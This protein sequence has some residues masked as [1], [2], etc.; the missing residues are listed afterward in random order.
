LLLLIIMFS[1]FFLLSPLVHHWWMYLFQYSKQFSL[2]LTLILNTKKISVFSGRPWQ[3]HFRKHSYSFIWNAVTF[4]HFNVHRLCMEHATEQHTYYESPEP[5][6]PNWDHRAPLPGTKQGNNMSPINAFRLL[7]QRIMKRCVGNKLFQNKYLPQCT[8]IVL[9]VRGWLKQKA[10]VFIQVLI[11]RLGP[12]SKIKKPGLSR[13]N[14]DERS[15]YAYC[16][17]LSSRI[18]RNILQRIC[19]PF[20]QPQFVPMQ[21]IGY[22]TEFKEYLKGVQQYLKHET[23]RCKLKIFS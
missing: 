20:L 23:H 16:G 6:D 19:R 14:L 5:T 17:A 22:G 21:R 18:S 4:W 9:R 2:A 10:G 13:L 15:A 8:G 12:R 1:F 3:R 7:W 11:N